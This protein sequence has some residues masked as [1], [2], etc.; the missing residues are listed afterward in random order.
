MSQP[1]LT[2]QHDRLE[3]SSPMKTGMRVMLALAGCFPLIAPW[4][5]LFRVNWQDI[6]NPFFLF[7]AVVSLGAVAVSALFFFAAIAGLNSRLLFDKRTGMFHYMY[8]APVIQQK[9]HTYPLEAIHR[10]DVKVYEWSEGSPGYTVAVSMEDARIFESGSSCSR[11]EM[12]AMVI[13]I[14]EFLGDRP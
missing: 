1:F 12:E 6:W 8:D 5:L 10:I 13:H 3:V 9:T 14:N 11:E 2:E 4:E 7:A